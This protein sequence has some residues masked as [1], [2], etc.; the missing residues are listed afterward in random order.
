M[1]RNWSDAV[2]RQGPSVWRWAGA[3]FAAVAMSVGVVPALAA[4]ANMTLT[5]TQTPAPPPGAL[6]STGTTDNYVT[7][8]LVLTNVGPSTVNNIVV[9]ANTTGTGYPSLTAPCVVPNSVACSVG[10]SDFKLDLATDPAVG[11]DSSNRPGIVLSTTQLKKGQTLTASL[12]FKT[13]A[14]GPLSIKA[15]A[16]GTSGASSTTPSAQTIVKTIPYPTPAQLRE[17]PVAPN[18]GITMVQV[19]EKV[20]RSVADPGCD[21]SSTASSAGP[22]VDGC[23]FAIYKVT[24]TNNSGDPSIPGPFYVD[25]TGTG[26][27]PT[28]ATDTPVQLSDIPACAGSCTPVTISPVTTSRVAITNLATTNDILVQFT[29]PIGA[30]ATSTVRAQIVFPDFGNGGYASTATSNLFAFDAPA[31]DGVLLPIST[32]YGGT[33]QKTKT[34][35]PSSGKYTSAFK[36]PKDPSHKYKSLSTSVDETVGNESCSPSFKICLD[37]TLTIKT[38]DGTLYHQDGVLDETN[39]SILKIELTRDFN[40]FA[41]SGN[42]LHSTIYYRP[43]GLGGAK[44]NVPDCGSVDTTSPTTIRC[45]LRTFNSLKKSNKNVYISGE[46]KFVI[47]AR[48]NGVYSW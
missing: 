3:T 2:G 4:D 8:A 39:S 42:A 9:Y 47:I 13:P 10:T 44:V 14:S 43:D 37:T 11:Q 15:L 18:V 5:L 38:G 19:S 17:V 29:T 28:P 16:L 20:A 40:T 22:V 35:T 45:I 32:N 7:F 26:M 31:M 27:P 36:I 48:E 41:S 30:T 24:V 21:L 23:G 33:V 34:D 6:R 46:V 12:A 1:N 25:F